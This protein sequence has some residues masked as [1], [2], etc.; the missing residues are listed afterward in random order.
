LFVLLINGIGYILLKLSNVAGDTKQRSAVG[1]GSDVNTA[2]D[3]K[4]KVQLVKKLA[5]A[6]H[7]RKFSQE[8]CS[9]MRV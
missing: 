2:V 1:D 4:K 7:S 5:S 6:R 8:K 9:V 3:S